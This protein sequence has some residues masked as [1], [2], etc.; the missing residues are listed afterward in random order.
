MDTSGCDPLSDVILAAL[1]EG[2]E[3]AVREAVADHAAECE[4]CGGRPGVLAAIAEGLD[5]HI[6]AVRPGFASRVMNEIRD[7]EQH[8][9]AFDRLPP[10]WQMAG[11]AALFVAL[12]AVVLAGGTGAEGAWHSRALTGFV[13][14]TLVF[15]GTFSGA[16]RGLWD[17]VV[18]GRGLPILIGCAVVATVLNVG[19][20]LSVLK[21]KTV[22]DD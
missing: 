13:D 15:L 3:G 4:P 18:P 7:R 11:A 21:R 2:R 20:A 16:I 6:P 5:P 8:A 19:F 9:G 1:E 17:A 10:P 12:A 14:Q 22:S